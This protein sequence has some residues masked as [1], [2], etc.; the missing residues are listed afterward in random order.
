MNATK[1]PTKKGVKK[2]V[3]KKQVVKQPAKKPT[4]QK[5]AQPAPQPV[6]VKQT[7]VKKVALP[8]PKE[9]QVTK[10]DIGVVVV[11]K[12]D[13]PLE[14][15]LLNSLPKNPDSISG[16]S[17]GVLVDLPSREEEKHIVPKLSAFSQ[18]IPIVDLRSPVESPIT[19]VPLSSGKLIISDKQ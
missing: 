2:P 16:K 18:G 10:P 13:L 4:V 7:S 6:K 15:L 19:T 11:P 12:E 3:A 9:V 14:V 5:K 17:K 1:S 8:K